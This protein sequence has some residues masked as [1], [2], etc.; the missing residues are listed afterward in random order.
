MCKGDKEMK[1]ILS[2]LLCLCLMFY[3][4]VTVNA[5]SVVEENDPT[6]LSESAVSELKEDYDL[7]SEVEKK[8]T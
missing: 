5:N 3:S 2:F 6:I 8:N 7:T 4:C 1:K